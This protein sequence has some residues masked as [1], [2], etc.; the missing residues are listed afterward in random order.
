MNTKP[1]MKPISRV[2]KTPGNPRG[3]GNLITYKSGK[4]ASVQS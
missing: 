1:M 2:T 3:N 4:E